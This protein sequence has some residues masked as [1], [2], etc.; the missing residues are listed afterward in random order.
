LVSVGLDS[1]DF[2]LAVESA[3][4]VDVGSAGFFKRGGPSPDAGVSLGCEVVEGAV[5]E[6]GALLAGGVVFAVG[7]FVSLGGSSLVSIPSGTDCAVCAVLATSDPAGIHF[8][9]PIH[10]AC[11]LAELLCSALPTVNSPLELPA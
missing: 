11:T 2:G 1:V 10:R 6:A 3:G 8:P 9:M 7:F 4:R 5:V